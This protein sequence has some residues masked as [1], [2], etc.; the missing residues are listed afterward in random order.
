MSAIRLTLAAATWTD[1]SATVAIVGD[2]FT[3]ITPLSDVSVALSV[4]EPSSGESL[5]ADEAY[6]VSLN[7]DVAD[8]LKVW[9]HST[10]GGNIRFYNNGNTKT[11]KPVVTVGAEAN[12]PQVPPPPPTRSTWV[13]SGTSAAID[14]PDD[15]TWFRFMST[16]LTASVASAS[17][18]MGLNFG[19]T[20]TAQQW[21]GT[22]T[23]SKATT[24]VNTIMT[25]HGGFAE[26]PI[27]AAF[28]RW[29]T[30]TVW[31]PRD[32]TKK[33]MALG[34][35]ISEG[36]DEIRIR[37]GVAIAAKDDDEIFISISSGN[38]AGTIHIEWFYN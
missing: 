32:A 20:P 21:A 4:A 5:T 30:G 1:V 2:E 24:L 6:G 16:T 13:V 3:M 19:P 28:T 33:S 22:Q 8:A 26:A 29:F 25:S 12:I 27:D 37:R 15:V 35:G 10:A 14:I 18:F 11:L 34:E 36:T 7:S 9:V 31:S 38:F 23:V 17:I